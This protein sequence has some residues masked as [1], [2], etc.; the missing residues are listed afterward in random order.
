VTRAHRPKRRIRR[1]LVLSLYALASALLVAHDLLRAAEGAVWLN[2]YKKNR[3][4]EEAREH[5]RFHWYSLRS[6]LWEA[7]H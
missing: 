3:W 2:S 1:L 5:A 6:S 7:L 4:L